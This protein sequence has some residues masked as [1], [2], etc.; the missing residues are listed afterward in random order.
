MSVAARRVVVLLILA[1]GAAS[2]VAWWR[3]TPRRDAPAAPPEWPPFEPAESSPAISPAI[4]PAGPSATSRWRAADADA[5]NP[6]D[7]FPI[8]VKESSKIYHLPGGR[9]YDRTK[10]D[11][12]YATADAAEAD[13]YRRSKT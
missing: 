4:S 6:P 13:G 9:F 12:W 10:P 5:T 2:V 8:K 11:R 3:G 1:G 7:G